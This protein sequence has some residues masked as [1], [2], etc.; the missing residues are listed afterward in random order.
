MDIKGFFDNISHEKL[1]LAVEKMSFK[2]VVGIALKL[3]PRFLYRLEY[4]GLNVL[5]LFINKLWCI[6][7]I[8]RKLN[9]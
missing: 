8:R 9:P 5:L 3:N 7:P 4:L 1:M 2:S 6:K